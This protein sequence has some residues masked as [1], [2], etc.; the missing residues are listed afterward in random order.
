MS[1]FLIEIQTT[2]P[3]GLMMADRSLEDLIMRAR[4][5]LETTEALIRDLRSVQENLD[6]TPTMAGLTPSNS[7][8]DAPEEHN[9]PE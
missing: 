7:P 9:S 8:A 1:A 2:L 6:S 5:L 3:R 4:R